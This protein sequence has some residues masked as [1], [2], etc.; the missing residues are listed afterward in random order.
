MLK[1]ISQVMLQEADDLLCGLPPAS[2][3]EAITFSTINL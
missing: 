1:T 3:G 2:N